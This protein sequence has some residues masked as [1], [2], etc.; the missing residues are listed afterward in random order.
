MA[1]AIWGDPGH[2]SGMVRYPI[3]IVTLVACGGAAQVGAPTRPPETPA[4]AE[5]SPDDE[6]RTA[7]V[8]AHGVELGQNEGVVAYSNCSERCIDETPNMVD[9]G[10]GEPVYTGIIYQ[11]VEYARRWWL[12]KRGVVFGS[13]DTADD[14]WTEVRE[15]TSPT[16][17]SA[18]RVSPMDNGGAAAPEVGDLVIYARDPT[19]PRLRFGHVTV[20]VGVDL[21]AGV[22]FVAEQNFDNAPWAEADSHARILALD[23][24]GDRFTL[25]DDGVPDARIYGWLHLAAPPS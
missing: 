22:V 9:L 21:E 19:M 16:G 23:T 12:M 20:V 4:L 5:E 7:C 8:T 15:A 13:V 18:F 17:D 24:E 6:C 2:G 14:M 1:G 10:A 11:C 25:R 3:V